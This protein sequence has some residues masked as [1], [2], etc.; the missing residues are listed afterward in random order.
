MSLPELFPTPR[1]ISETGNSFILPQ[2]FRFFCSDDSLSEGITPWTEKL[3]LI[4]AESIEQANLVIQKESL[5]HPEAYFLK[6]END[7][8]TLK[9][10]TA[11]G[12]FRGL[13]KV[14]EVFQ[15][16]EAGTQIPGF[17]IEDAPSLNRRGF[18]LDI[19]RCKVPTMEELFRLIDLLAL[20]GYNE[21]QL[22]IEHTFRFQDHETVWKDASPVLCRAVH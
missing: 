5:G 6:L 14:F 10:E 13:S 12:V 15:F 18:M 4:Q 16:R 21:L 3:S 2:E 20:I 19:S 7:Q 11:S 9:A 1:K 22:Y 8:I 17:V